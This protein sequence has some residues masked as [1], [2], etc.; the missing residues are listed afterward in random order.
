MLIVLT[1]LLTSCGD[2]FNPCNDEFSECSAPVESHWELKEI[3]SDIGNG[4]GSFNPVDSDRSLTFL[5][6]GTV[7][8]RGSMCTLDATSTEIHR[9]MVSSSQDDQLIFAGCQNGDE[10]RSL[11]F[12]IEGNELKVY[13]MCIE[14]CVHKYKR[15]PVK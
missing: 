3:Y 5:T 13:F 2:K 8:S 11:Y 7:I 9:G 1:G 4:T 6:D 10:E 12:E 15:V 14:A